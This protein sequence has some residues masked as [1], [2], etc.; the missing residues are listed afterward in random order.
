[1]SLKI[2]LVI[3]TMDR[4]GAERQVC[5][6]AAGLLQ[7]GHQP[8]VVL[9]TR[10]GPRV[11]ELDA[12]GVPHSLV[13]KR[14]KFDPTAYWRLKQSL[15]QLAPQVVHTFLFAANSYG[16]AAACSLKIP[17]VIG[18]ERCVDLWKTWRHAI[19]DR[20]LAN[21]SQAISTNS[22]GVVDFYAGRGIDP[23]LF[24]VI[25]NAIPERRWLNS[26]RIDV[27][28][29]YQIDPAKKWVVA[30]GRLWPQK[31]YRDIIWAADM[32]NTLR[33]NDTTLVIVG[34]G[35]QR[36]ELQ[37]YRDAISSPSQ[38]YFA[39]Q[40]KDVG[41]LLEHADAFWL[42]SEF[43]GQS[44]ALMEAMQ[45]GV[46]CVVSD[47]PGNRDLVTHDGTGIVVK[48]GDAADFARQTQHLW[49]HP[50]FAKEIGRNAQ[51]KIAQQFTI[52]AMVDAHIEL[53]ESLL[54]RKTA[55]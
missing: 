20:R 19:I 47:I 9:L 4:G 50:E 32:L 30:V 11:E 45:A 33:G 27:A 53:Y 16:R 51:Q 18:S 1:M 37:R 41:D 15:R 10:E 26:N 6:L 52:S 35:P 25:P 7:R 48:L 5:L 39:G 44:N 17:V 42:A 38:V 34:D 22:S 2:A 31:R 21:C 29:R 55:T 54:A 36:G 8:H 23:Q 24:R 46:P 40:R 28:S 14:A 43:E 3:P 13:G 12:A 49:D